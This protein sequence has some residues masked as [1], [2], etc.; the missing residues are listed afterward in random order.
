MPTTEWVV[1]P[2]VSG[3][4]IGNPTN[5]AAEALQKTFDIVIEQDGL[6][7]YHLGM[8]VEHPEQ[9]E[10]MINWT[11][12][13]KHMEWRQRPE[14][15]PAAAISAPVFGEGG[16]M[17]HVDFEP[18]HQSVKAFTKPVTQ[19][20]TFFYDGV[21][22]EGILDGVHKFFEVLRREKVPGALSS[23]AGITYEEVEFE[24]GKGKA[25]VLVI[26]WRSIEDHLAFKKTK[27]YE[28]SIP[29]L[30]TDEAAKVDVHHVKFVMHGGKALADSKLAH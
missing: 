19:V 9:L 2:V 23:A 16:F 21:P 15:D 25:V 12:L 5:F 6:L 4:D 29:L 30:R 7:E 26:G 24:D 11:S 20:A 22:P 3:G 27:L 1:A 8:Q 17:R 18:Y 14:H 10:A 28:D 13:D